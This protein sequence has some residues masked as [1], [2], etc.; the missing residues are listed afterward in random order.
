MDN[1]AQ[2]RPNARAGAGAAGTPQNPAGSE[3][4][5]DPL[6]LPYALVRDGAAF[7]GAAELEPAPAGG[8]YIRRVPASVRARLGARGRL[9][10]AESTGCELRFVTS[11]PNADV[12]LALPAQD[13]DV[14]VYRG[15]MF[16][17]EHRLKAGHV[18]V[19]RLAAPPRL[20]GAD[21]ARLSASGFAPDV[22]RVRFARG[23]AVY[24]GLNAFGEAVR[25]PKPGEVPAATLLA[26]G[27]SITHGGE[28]SRSAYIGQAAR[29]LGLDLHNLGMSGSCL[30]EREMID[31][32]AARSDWHILFLELGVNM[33][34][35]TDVGEFRSRVRYALERI[36]DRHP[37]KPIFLTTIYPNFAVLGGESPQAGEQDLRFNEI[38]RQ[39]TRRM[40]RG[41]LLHLFEGDRILDD[42]GGLSC[43]L[44]HPSDDG[45]SVMG[46]NLANLMCGILG[47]NF[48][49]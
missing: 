12:T 20:N 16:H 18:A 37:D 2:D 4:R 31:E 9:I 39:E 6:P 30:C 19:L 47:P 33:R 49:R 48:V 1:Q 5:P 42:P 23:E 3:S 7:H 22:W 11:S 27:S 15:G 13:G 10:A 29:R 36:V 38:L 43:D 44:V 14:A 17:S 45:H 40:D 8:L 24:Y 41:A 35:G 46:A 34:D 25:P 32:I 21:P 28:Q 26:Y